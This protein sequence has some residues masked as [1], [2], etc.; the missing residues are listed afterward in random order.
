MELDTDIIII[1]AGPAG[2]CLAR[3]LAETNLRI[4]LIDKQTRQSLAEPA[5]D[6]REIA[7]THMSKKILDKTGI[8]DM[9]PEDKVSHIKQA[10]V[11]NGRSPFALSFDH[12]SAGTDTLG[13]MLS[14][15]RIRKAAFDSLAGFQNVQLYDGAEV[16]N[17]QTDKHQGSVD[18][19]DG[20]RLKAKLVVAADSRFSAARRMMGISASMQD[21][22]RTC[23]VC[24]MQ[25]EMPHDDI[26]YE[27]FHNDLT[28]AVLPL[29]DNRVSVVVTAETARATEIAGMA[30]G[31]FSQDIQRRFENR[32]GEMTLNSKLFSYPLVATFADSFVARRF[33]MVG[34]A[35]VGMHPV[36]AHGFNLGVQGSEILSQA[37]RSALAAG[38]D[39]ASADILSRYLR[40]HRRNCLPLYH[41]TNALVRLYTRQSHRAR[42]A[43]HALLRIANRLEP[44]KRLIT[45]Q[46]TQKD[47]RRGFLSLR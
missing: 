18:L 2:L 6:G 21:F 8:W 14:N 9:I 29:T 38:E 35:A 3:N 36:T 37:I 27:C 22:G 1:G 39:F 30:P 31:Q 33:V 25:T 26:A 19:A 15:H 12:R 11:L 7:L 16:A 23:I 5:Y 24:T 10:K 40:E 47:S 28:L 4:I 17:V 32:L 13:F 45:N 46:L 44:A 43:R 42:F 20:R 34:D 41:G